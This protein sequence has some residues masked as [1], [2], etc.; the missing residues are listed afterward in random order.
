M[1]TMAHQVADGTDASDALKALVAL[2]PG[3]WPA[4]TQ[5]AARLVPDLWGPSGVVAETLAKVLDDIENA[6]RAF[7]NSASG[8]LR[9]GEG[10]SVRVGPLLARRPTRGFGSR[11]RLAVARRVRAVTG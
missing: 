5:L 8:A 6:S 2:Y 7:C 10:H 9:N 4:S 11:T 1:N 3:R